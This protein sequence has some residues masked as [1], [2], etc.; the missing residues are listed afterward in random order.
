M[1]H[2]YKCPGFSDIISGSISHEIFFSD[3]VDLESLETAA[4]I[5]MKVNE[6]LKMLQELQ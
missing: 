5:M 2:L 6:R 1:E 3:D 4:D